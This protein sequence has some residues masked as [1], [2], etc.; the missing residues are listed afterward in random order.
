MPN[1][2]LSPKQ[3]EALA[4][5]LSERTI[6]DAAKKAGVPKRTLENWLYHDE[7][8]REA[9]ES[10][11]MAATESACNRL[12]LVAEQAIATLEKNLNA[13]RAADQNRAA[14]TLLHHLERI[15]ERI[16]TAKRIRSI[17]QKIAALKREQG[18]KVIG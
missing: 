8:F 1:Q 7:D 6:A 16:D 3:A 4:A 5:L 15:E 18:L 10:A 13:R 2:S 9:Y 17:E 11:C 14:A 12:R